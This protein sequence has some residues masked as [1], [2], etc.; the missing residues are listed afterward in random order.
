MYSNIFLITFFAASAT[1]S[2][3][4]EK[5]P[6]PKAPKITTSSRSATAISKIRFL[7]STQI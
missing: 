6:H 4:L 7:P 1:T 2:E 5:A 3:L